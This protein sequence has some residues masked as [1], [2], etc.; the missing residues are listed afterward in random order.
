MGILERLS[1]TARAFSFAH[2]RLYLMKLQQVV[3]PVK[4]GVQ[5]NSCRIE[6][7]M[8]ASAGMTKR[9]IVRLYVLSE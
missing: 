9:S 7:W 6:H 1:A 5:K 2:S 4:T 8:P 3:T